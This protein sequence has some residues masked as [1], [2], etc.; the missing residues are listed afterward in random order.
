MSTLAELLVELGINSDE[1]TNGAEG[2]ANEVNNS[3]AGIGGAAAGAA[4][5]AAFAV[6]M[7]AAMDAS[8]A[9]A[10]LTAQL[11][12]TKEEAARAGDIAGDVFSAGW[13]E[14]IDEVNE[15]I[16]SVGSALGGLSEITDDE[17]REMSTAALALAKTF[18]LD[19]ADAATAAA[20][21]INN[22][23]VKDG[24]EAFDVLTKAAQTLPKS[25]ME[26]IPAAITEYGKHWS[27]IGLDAKD[28]MGMMSQ[29]VKAG[30]RDI[31][32]AG[33]VLHEFARITSEETDKASEAFKGLGLPAKEMLA[34]IHK[35]GEPAKAAL[36]K[37]IEALRGV[38]DQGK[39]SALAVELF[40][41][42]AGEGADALWAMDPATAAASSGMDKAAGSA[43]AMEDALAKDPMMAYDSIVRSL[44]TQLGEFLA[45]A[46]AKVAL[47][48]KEHPAA[49]QAIAVTLGILAV[50]LAVAAAAQWAM[51]LAM[52]AN[53][54]TWI[55]LLIVGLV[56]VIVYLATKTKFFQEAWQLM[57]TI[58]SVAWE[59]LWTTVR[60]LTNR[61]AAWMLT[62]IQSLVTG[63]ADIFD[64]FASLP[65]I[66][67]G[68]FMRMTL[69]A[70]ERI[71]ALITWV[72][73]IP[74]RVRD[75][76]GDLGG[77]LKAAGRAILQGLINGVTERIGDLRSKFRSITGMIP[78]W[79]GPMSLDLQL[80]TP[81]GEA[82]MSGLIDG[83]DDSLPALRRTLQGVTNEIPH[84]VNVGVS[85]TGS[86]A[87]QEVVGRLV[88]DGD[89]DSA[90]ATAIARS[91]RTDGG[92]SVQAR[93][94]Q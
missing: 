19:V 74:Q 4:V 46:L 58:V 25:M 3:L 51:N 11:G 14:S 71:T 16:G 18:E 62:K 36:Q 73:G 87:A 83:V 41:D 29:Y 94:G 33:D 12:L 42:M 30:G 5:G 45:P 80:L 68:H 84:N 50:A 56:A 22:K 75:A 88:I 23:L 93:Y 85:R 82:L 63:I 6:G 76:V 2:A 72:R 44:T 8:S 78:D 47:F 15:A 37:T 13:G 81:S 10:K 67:G 92:G 60:D 34:N 27:R 90:F 77:I 17:M 38:K 43:K 24:A 53:P 49:F 1:L 79:K 48:A 26:D 65:G 61:A 91:V 55:V 35:G 54:I 9:N 32:Q 57:S 66:I 86:S 40:G 59:W 64:F 20:T 39:Q 28:A 69:A 52:L 7:S 70:V 89:A 31:D 21:L